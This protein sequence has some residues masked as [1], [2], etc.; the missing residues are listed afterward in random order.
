MG[1]TNIRADNAD[2]S[3]DYAEHYDV[4]A[5]RSEH[6]TGDETGRSHAKEP[7]SRPESTVVGPDLCADIDFAAPGESPGHN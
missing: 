2:C 4:G 5:S 1:S 6:E 3:E 7:S